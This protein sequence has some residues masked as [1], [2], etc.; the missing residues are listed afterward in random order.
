MANHNHCHA[1]TIMYFEVLRHFAIYQELASV[2]ECVLVP[3]LLTRFTTNNVAKWRDIL[4]PALLPMPSETYLQPFTTMAG[5][6]REHPL[7]KAFDADQ[8]IKTQYANVDFPPGSYDDEPIR[9]L[10]GQ[11]MLRVDLPRP[12]TRYDRIKSLPVTTKTVV[13]Q[14]DIDVQ[15]TV[16]QSTVDAFLAG[17]TAGLSTL[18]TGPPGSNVQYQTKETQVQVKQAIFDAFMSLDANYESVRP[19]DCIRVTNFSPSSIS[20][21]GVTV[22]VSG[23]DFFQDG[24]D[25]RDQWAR[26]ASLMGYTDVLK[27]LDYYFKGRLIS[28][29]DDI[30]YNDIVPVIFRKIVDA[31]AIS[32]LS[33]DFTAEGKYTGGERLM[34]L[35]LSG[36]TSLKRNQLPPQLSM[37]VTSA[38]VRALAD[39]V[40]LDVEDVSITYSTAHYNGLLYGGNVNNDLLDGVLLDIPENPAEKRNPRREDRY[41]AAKLL[42]HLNSNLEYYNKV[43]WYRLDPDRRYMLLDG[44]SIQVYKDDGTPVLGDGGMRS[45]ASVVKN[46][47]IAVAGN[48]LV[49][50][51]AP[52]YK[53]SGSFVTPAAQNGDTPKVGLIDHYKPLTPAKPYRISTPCRGVFAEAVQGACD[54]CERIETDRLQDWSRYPIDDQPTAITP[55][56]V[57]TPTVTDWQAAF[58]DFA[59]PI[60]NVQNA[61][62]LPATG[63][64]LEGLTQLLAQS[65]IFKD[66]TGLDAN[67]QNV[68]R[69]YLSN[70]D[71]AKAF[72]EMAKE[73]AMQ[74]HNTQNSGKIMDSIATA[75][76]SG[77]ITQ[78]QA[79]QLT[80][81][82]L[83]QQIDGGASTRA[84]AAAAQQAATPSLIPA[85]VGAIGDNKHVVASRTDPGGTT[86]SVDIQPAGGTGGP[87]AQIAGALPSL[88]QD[89]TKGDDCWAVA[90]AMMVGWKILNPAI[91]VAEAVERAGQ[92]YLAIYQS[93]QGLKGADKDDFLLRMEMVAEPPASYGLQQYIDWIDT[94]GPVWVTVDAAVDD[95][96]WAPHARVL[97]RI[98]GT[99]TPDGVGTDM[100]F[101]D[102]ATGTEASQPFLEFIKA[103]EE[104]AMTARSRTPSPQV[105]HFIEELDKGE[106]FQIQGPWNFHAPIH[107]TI[108]LAA[109]MNSDLAVP[110]SVKLGADQAVNELIRGV[111]WNDDPA[112]LMFH[113]DVKT[114]WHFSTG[115]SWVWAFERAK[116]SPTNNRQNLTGRSH[117]FDL[118]F[119]HAMAVAEGEQPWDTLAH[120]LLWAE[121]MYRLS[122]G[123]GIAPTDK[124]QDIHVTSSVTNPAGDAFTA[125]FDGLFDGQSRPLGSDTINY[126]ISLDTAC[127]S[128][129]ISRRAIGSLLHLVQDSYARGHTRRTLLNPGDLL[130]G[131]SDLFK[132]GTYGHLGEVENFHC[133][134]GQDEDLHDK[135][136]VPL[137]GVTPDP[138]DLSTFNSTF[139]GRDAL[140]HTVELLNFWNAKTPWAANGGPKELLEGTIFKLSK[141]VTPADKTV[142]PPPPKL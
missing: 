45:L 69:T 64:G 124:L 89:P 103:F 101:V 85:T 54:A 18:F 53:V 24:I 102:P 46:D 11:M 5:P 107:E 119:V 128:L 49:F 40:T 126:L 118:S 38:D 105:V 141:D 3:F 35:S 26:Y 137:D 140:D 79:G 112:V 52:G 12:K 75:K 142:W 39:H 56:G 94:Y 66:I 42:E 109:A 41:L 25:D 32:P 22:P 8:R 108:T 84:Q 60:V 71:N 133:Y 76:S 51:V 139:G 129:D 10:T 87:L 29:W 67:Q 34:P 57:P 27:F 98:S 21:G 73:M 86:E 74:S 55:V 83:Q 99:G 1:L 100:T 70:Q 77:A 114:N 14:G 33:T 37:S 17:A 19:A 50:P 61:P 65:G 132:P 44:Y 20:F 131:S 82:H 23:L 110:K 96:A 63:A 134:R 90:A 28:E 122:T 68:L 130:P 125:E 135:Y 88:K 59:A 9:F 104:M 92:R 6:G 95:E 2:E 115:V 16:K 72:A 113:E 91:T 43:L 136:D 48:S 117:F 106:G 58:K 123:D 30:F 4:A 7:I 80:K 15:A 138:T 36:K 13:T 31:I 62:A 78:Q 111:I 81:D 116:H 120:I 121:V 97:T 127:P 47:M 93:G